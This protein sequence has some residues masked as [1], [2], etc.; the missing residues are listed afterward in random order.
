MCLFKLGVFCQLWGPSGAPVTDVMVLF[1]HLGDATYIFCFALN[2][3]PIHKYIQ[4]A[5]IDYKSHC[6]GICMYGI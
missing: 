6:L 4:N 5:F 2:I 1:K 3:K